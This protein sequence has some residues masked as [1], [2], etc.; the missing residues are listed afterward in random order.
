MDALK[1][2]K[3]SIETDCWERMER[4]WYVTEREKPKYCGKNL[5]QLPTTVSSTNHRWTHPGLNPNSRG[6]L[7]CK[8]NA[9]TTRG[10]VE[11]ELQAFLT[12]VVTV[13]DL[14]S[15][16]SCSV[17]SA[18]RAGVTEEAFTWAKGPSWKRRQRGKSPPYRQ[19][20]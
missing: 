14:A 8:N 9:W 19:L 7:K 16:L 4:E 18:E 3:H 2:E 5:F 13:R 6:D 17:T 11:V 15:S 10:W 1:R 12:A 20:I